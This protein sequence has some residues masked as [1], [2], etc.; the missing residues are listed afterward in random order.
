MASWL[1]ISIKRV[2]YTYSKDILFLFLLYFIYYFWCTY[3]IV[4]KMKSD[5]EPV[6]GR[7]ELDELAEAFF[8]NIVN[9]LKAAYA[10]SNVFIIKKTDETISSCLFLSYPWDDAINKHLKKVFE[11]SVV[12]LRMGKKRAIIGAPEF[13]YLNHT[14]KGRQISSFPVKDSD[15]FLLI[16]NEQQVL[17]SD[18]EIK[19]IELLA[20]SVSEFLKLSRRNLEFESNQNLL[21]ALSEINREFVAP[22]SDKNSLFKKML[23]KMLYITNS[24]YGFIGE[25]LLRDGKPYLKIYAITDASWDEETS[26]Q[27]QNNEQ[28]G[29]EFTNL[30]T[31]F[32]YTIKT[33]EPV[34]SNDPV[35]DTKRGGLPHGHSPLNDYLG[36]PLYDKENNL[37]GMLGLG[38]KIGG[39]SQEDIHFL[40][41]II[42]LA[43]AFI[44]SI[45]SNEANNRLASH[46]NI[47]KD[48]I[49]SH[50]I[51]AVTDGEGKI[52]Y[53]NERFCE[54]SKYSAAD[55]I[56]QNHRIINSGFHPKSFFENLWA[57]LLAGKKWHGEIRNKAKDGTT[58]WVDTT[59]V[60]FMDENN[61]PYQFISIRNDITQLKEQEQELLNFFRLSVELKCIINLDGQ[62]I[63]VSKSFE[64]LLGYA[65]KEL[66]HT[67]IYRFILPEDLEKITNE[68]LKFPLNRKPLNFVVRF[69]KKDKGIVLMRWNASLNPEGNLIYGTATDI[70]QSEELQNKLIESRIE[71]EKA[72]AKDDFLANMSHEIRTPL[73]AIIGFTNLLGET[74]LNTQQR[75]HI[76]IITSALKN[77]SVII[78]DILDISKMESGKLELEKREFS[79]ENLAKQ[80]IQMHTAKARSKNIKLILSYDNEIPMLI[81]GDETRLSQ[82]LTNLIS[83]AIK[84]TSEGFIELRI[85]EKLRNEQRSTISFSVID[86]G[87]GI[88]KSKLK[89]I[90]ERFSQAEDYTT[91]IY[92]GTGLGLNIVKSLVELHHGKLDVKSTPGKGSEFTVDLTYIFV[93][94]D[95]VDKAIVKPKTSIIHSLEGKKILLVEDN[96]HNQI[97]A[98][99]YIERRKGSVE[100]AGNGK[101]ALAMLAK[102]NPYDLILMDIQ[103][104][105]MDGL[106]TTIQIRNKLKITT[107]IIGCSAH[108][109]ASERNMCLETGMNDY[110]TKPYSEAELVNSVA[111]MIE[112]GIG[113]VPQPT[114]DSTSGS[115]QF[116]FLFDEIAQEFGQD[117]KTK[118]IKLM[119][120][121]VPGDLKKMEGMM[122]SKN[123][124]QFAE[125][126]HNL[127]GSLG[128]LKMHEGLK[129][130][131]EFENAIKKNNFP[132]A[133]KA[134]KRL[135]TYLE[136]FIR[137]TEEQNAI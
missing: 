17:L 121:R 11:D 61:K 117:A 41:P 85:V 47:Y 81:I 77:L 65:E 18:M 110:I 102:S 37:I 70:T 7:L 107:P 39:Y 125:L 57:C 29:M 72:K 50:S 94:P 38:N 46:L 21:K 118:L 56:G 28:D 55:L 129:L 123:Y 104:P 112:R 6:A 88:D 82:I 98:K 67:L 75:N 96:E 127:A 10:F 80:V 132:L 33:G 62:L 24:E 27:Y 97:L 63:K 26:N 45:K 34:I 40:E 95:D 9:H 92:G 1:A 122:K 36:I 15:Y 124:K 52:T 114:L 103:M 106:Q 137:Y 2:R 31:L 91:R 131:R 99:T 134:H 74:E 8:T 5:F 78:N 13:S 83:N 14:V 60:P 51:L 23:A 58:Y 101:I 93:K 42:S 59:I 84:F 44:Y 54:I 69:V 79:L 4:Y 32:G 116:D 87:I 20:H 64:D 43:S 48:A 66:I 22:N 113:Q 100:I 89:K 35:N 128:S 53:V 86:S 90:F 30:N 126:I 119:V 49:D 105:I 16:D 108:A 135:V 130:A 76:Q 73:N 12:G 115:D 111:N 71:M 25:T 133:A 120:E 136:R 68:I 19:S 3:Y 109:L